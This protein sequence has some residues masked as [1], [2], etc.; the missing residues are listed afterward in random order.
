[1]REGA[2]RESVMAPMFAALVSAGAAALT[3]IAV[4]TLP[5]VAAVLAATASAAGAG[6]L[7]F[8]NARRVQRSM[9]AAHAAE[10][11]D[12]AR[13][14]DAA[15]TA[16]TAA[17][18]LA[19][20]QTRRETDGAKAELASRAEIEEAV[21]ETA[22][23]IA[24]INSSIRAING[25]V[26]RLVTTVVNAGSSAQQ[27]STSIDQVAGSASTLHE[28]SSTT[29]STVN[30]MTASVRLV[31]ES[32]DSVQGMAEESAAAMVQMD[33]AIREVSQ[34]VEDAARL[35]HQV[36]DGAA[37]GERAVEETI[38][39]I[40]EIRTQMLTARRAIEEL[41][42]RVG[43]IGEFLDMIGA[44]NEETNLLSLNAAIIAAQAGEQGKAFAVVA[45]HVKTLAQRTAGS[46]REIETLISAIQA[47]S[48]SATQAMFTGMD[49]VERGVERSKRAGEALVEIR[50][51]ADQA[52]ERVTEIARASLEQTRNSKHVAEAAQRTSERVQEISRA[53]SEQSRASE[54]L[55]QAAEGALDQCRQVQRVTAEQRGA[56]LTIR[57][58]V[59]AIR[60][61]AQSIQRSTESH[62]AASESVS[63]AVSR[64]LEIAQKKDLAP[65]VTAKLG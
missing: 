45:S 43:R 60:E 37:Q 8:G 52:S 25:E 47:A 46:T 55:M 56:A 39:G 34:H 15:S 7:L 28:V 9:D 54:N 4:S 27:M 29:A 31:A 44:I 18:A 24:H 33:R 51:S 35:T 62:S 59:G 50:G 3:A 10:L 14:R 32:S 1:M 53:I 5:G 11:A 41:V 40:A 13:E 17:R 22:S 63:E 36:S 58:A 2:S 48:S 21:E 38:R 30:E 61:M 12:L 42:T 20:E 49:A 6:A 16:L 65:R 57:D 19:A 26:E 64:I 23:L